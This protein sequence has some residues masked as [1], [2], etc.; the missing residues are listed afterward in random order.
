[1]KFEIEYFCTY[2]DIILCR[3]CIADGHRSC[4]DVV[5]LDIACAGSKT[6]VLKEIDRETKGTEIFDLDIAMLITELIG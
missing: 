3:A 5:V 1:M 6:T 2:H 4:K